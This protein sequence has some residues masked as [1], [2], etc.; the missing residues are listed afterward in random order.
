MLTRDRIA[1]AAL[2]L[3]AAGFVGI[4]ASEGWS[5]DA[6]IPVVGDVPTVGFGST[7]REDG[8][9]VAMGDTIT[10]PRAVVRS[11]AHIAEDESRLKKCVYAPLNQHEY[12]TLVDFSYQ[13]GPATACKSSIVKHINE[14]KYAE[15]C[16]AYLLYK[17]A[18]GY[19]CST[20]DNRRCLGV[21]TRALQR[22]NKCMGEP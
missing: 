7:I 14:H 4:I 2:A 5:E 18:G 13:F 3:S 12:D 22:R 15:A 10:P 20:P 21:W 16:D 6:V 11:Y 1:I 8:T 19:D 17:W 9:R